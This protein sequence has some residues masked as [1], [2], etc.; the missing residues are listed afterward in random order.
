M[1]SWLQKLS[2]E[3]DIHT[4]HQLE[5]CHPKLPKTHLTGQETLYKQHFCSQK[6]P[7]KE[8]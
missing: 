8:H 4:L 2:Q 5:I 1:L 7:E 6:N 3:I